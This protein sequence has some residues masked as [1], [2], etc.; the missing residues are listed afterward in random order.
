MILTEQVG[1]LSTPRQS[2]HPG[3]AGHT[4]VFHGSQDARPRVQS[5][6]C[7][8]VAEDKYLGSLW[9]RRQTS[10]SLGLAFDQQLGNGLLRPAV[11]ET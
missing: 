3:D 9:T 6:M 2:R 5:V 4:L 11:P 10:W 8:R 1:V 7:V